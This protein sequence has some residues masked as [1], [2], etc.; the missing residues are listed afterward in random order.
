MMLGVHIKL[1]ISVLA[2]LGADLAISTPMD[3]TK[4]RPS[5][6]IVDCSCATNHA[7]PKQLQD[8]A[9]YQFA[10][11]SGKSSKLVKKKIQVTQQLQEMK[12][13]CLA[14][15]SGVS[16]SVPGFKFHSFQHQSEE[17]PYA[18]SQQNVVFLPI[19]L[20][21]WGCKSGVVEQVFKF[22]YVYHVHAA[23]KVTFI[24]IHQAKSNPYI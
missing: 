17:Q 11:V 6:I 22:V 2:D 14:M 7:H 16:G 23:A 18:V 21:S 20:K 15:F 24:T 5:W 8:I 9:G 3:Y 1:K 12:N 10:F 4:S 13:L 19:L